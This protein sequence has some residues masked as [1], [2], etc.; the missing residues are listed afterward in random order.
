M[1][2]KLL[3]LVGPVH[4]V[5][6]LALFA[7]GF[8]PE[9]LVDVLRQLPA[10]SSFAVSPFFAAVLGPTIAS[11]GLMFGFLVDRFIASPDEASWRTMLFAVLI[12]APLDSALC[13]YYGIWAGAVL[14]AAVFVAIFALLI[15]VRSRLD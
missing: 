2:E 10:S 11:W 14:N 7:A 4:V 3:K 1:T 15:A 13:L 6:G 9:T 8:F 12:W 5:G